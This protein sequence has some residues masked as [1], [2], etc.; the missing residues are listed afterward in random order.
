MH[1][2]FSYLCMSL[3]LL[4]SAAIKLLVYEALSWRSNPFHVTILSL[5]KD[6]RKYVFFF[7]FEKCFCIIDYHPDNRS[8]P[9]EISD[10]KK[11]FEQYKV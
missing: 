7:S 4:V 11:L 10:G 9:C 5:K 1:E 8:P 6:K 3:K 2:P